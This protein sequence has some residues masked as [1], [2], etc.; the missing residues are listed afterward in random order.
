MNQKKE[1][2]FKS[3]STGQMCDCAQYIAEVMCFR[4]AEKEKVSGL[5]YK[6]WNKS[7]KQD[8]QAQIVAATKLINQFGEES[9]LYFI[10]NQGK[11]LY[12]LGKFNPPKFI[13]EAMKK[14]ASEIENR[15]QEQLLLEPPKEAQTSNIKKNT[16]INSL[17]A[18]IK[19][20]EKQ[21]GEN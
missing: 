14:V 20:A 12:S 10:H 7:R 18:K 19:K 9:L 6:F 5:E 3:L 8:F 1:K 17:I 16:G 13:I 11:N 21:N 2:K 4:M 15:K